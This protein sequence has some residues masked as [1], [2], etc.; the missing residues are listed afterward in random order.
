M[1]R[2]FLAILFSL[3]FALVLLPSPSVALPPSPELN[4]WNEGPEPVR[5]PGESAVDWDARWHAWRQRL[6]NRIAWNCYNYGVNAM[7]MRPAGGGVR[8][9][10]GKGTAWPD[11]GAL[12]AAQWCE[13]VRARARRDGLHNVA[14]TPGNPIPT[15]PA[16]ENLVALGAKAGRKRGNVDAGDYHW[17]RLNG[18]GSWSHKRGESRAK[19]TYKDNLGLQQPLTDPRQAAQRDG[20]SLC[21]FMSVPKAGGDFGPIA[22]APVCTPRDGIVLA[23]A[24]GPSG[25]PDPQKVLTPSETSQLAALLPSLSPGNQVPDP[26]WADVP[27]GDLAG[28][29]VAAG[30]DGMGGIPPY[31]RAYLGKL[32]VVLADTIGVM[33][34]DDANGV[35]AFLDQTVM[36]QAT[37]DCVTEGGT[38]PLTPC[39]CS[40]EAV[41]GTPTA[42][43][44]ALFQAEPVEGGLLLRWQ[45]GD[46]ERFM[47]ADLER[48]PAATGPWASVPVERGTRGD[49]SFALD[50]NVVPGRTYFYRIVA[51]TRSGG[52]M[53]FGPLAGMIGVAIADITLSPV[54]P[55]PTTGPARIEF[56][57]PRESQVR[58][59]VLDVQGREVALLAHGLAGPGRVLASWSGATERGD[60]PAGLYF[61]RLQ[62]AGRTLTRQ[63]ILTR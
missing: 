27:A 61:V 51:T 37:E 12:T 25:L 52:V 32:E 55:S 9:H 53:T 62:V 11:T 63:L 16:G 2:R 14:W 31:L 29:V 50:R 41:G 3:A 7:T 4:Q 22:A 44:L 24:V 28:Y 49:V 56:A 30:V 5:M 58:L 59:S 48:A 23:M 18:D 39:Q 40:D 26:Q 21:G 45:F 47:N 36:E 54:V 46:P 19:T 1:H 43:L 34:F 35:E 6:L 42:T 57:L 20:Y 33:F 38:I 17:W 10:P 13:K 8:A 60:A 15:P